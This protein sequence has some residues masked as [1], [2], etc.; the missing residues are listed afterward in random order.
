MKT[1][2]LF[3]T[4][5]VIVSLQSFSQNLMYNPGFEGSI[6]AWYTDS[7]TTSQTFWVDYTE[8]HSGVSSLKMTHSSSNDTSVF[9]QI[10]PVTAGKKYFFEYWVK[11]QNMEHYMLPFVRFAH[12]TSR[13][14]DT[15]FCPNGNVDD[16]QPLRA[17]FIVPDS[18]NNIIFFFALYGK[19]TLWF[20]DI[21]LIEQTD[22][23]YNEFSVDYNSAGIQL[24]NYFQ[25]NGIDPG[26]SANSLNFIDHFQEMGIDYVRT[27]DFAIAFDHSTIVG[28]LDTAYDP[29]DPADY[30]FHISDSM[31]AN[32]Y[33][34][35]GKI[36]YR[37]GQSYHW[38]TLYSVPPVNFNKWATSAVQIIKH[39]ND[40]WNNGFNYNIDY[41]E[42][43]N[44][45]DLK[46]FWRGTAQEY[47]AFYRTVTKA[48]KAYNPALKVGGPAISNV[49]NESFINEF[50]DSVATYNLPMDFFSYHF[51]Y[52]PNPYYFKLTNEYVRNK[53]NEYGLGG[54]E[55]IN[56]EWNTAMFNYQFYEVFG[57]DDG[58]NAASLTNALTYMQ[59]SDISKFFRY[60]FRNY[61]FGLVQENGDVRYSGLAMKSFRQLYENG[62]CMLSSG[63][64][65]LGTSIIATMGTDCHIIISDISSPA[66]GYNLLADNLTPGFDY[67][68]TIYRIS[69][70]YFYDIA[71]QGTITSANP[72]IHVP[73]VSPFSDHIII[74]QATTLADKNNPETKLYPNPSENVIT[75]EFGKIHELIDVEISEITGKKLMTGIFLNTDHCTIDIED[76]DNGVYIIRYK[77][78][79]CA[80]SFNFIKIE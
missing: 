36:F 26:N 45:P 57:M 2:F 69:D 16:W 59:E 72:Y 39:Y 49:F 1:K 76:L 41:F 50:L 5:S 14:F 13:V 29:L 34:A 43:W 77:N 63:G 55:L 38:D 31:A 15:Y 74:S 60:S 19:G 22:T 42:I 21:S 70:D 24:K 32:I 28:V 56:T 54:V 44:E 8:K 46:E 11:A 27:H 33:N 12:D 20:D 67:D 23:S 62:N 40:G 80:G 79:D 18:T 10:V 30:Y 9:A 78:G 66:A 52:L 6:F 47:I 7:N 53:L 64:D 37:L 51:Y 73:V 3:L 61:W 75:L 4:L 17:R 71:E 25:S 58:L 65:T 48:I 68:Y 35:G